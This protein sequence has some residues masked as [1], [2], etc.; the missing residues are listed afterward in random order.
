MTFE[1]LQEARRRLGEEQLEG[2][3][4]QECSE[5]PLGHDWTS[6]ETTVTQQRLL[7]LFRHARLRSLGRRDAYAT[8]R[9]A[10]GFGR[11]AWRRDW[12]LA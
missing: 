10:L 8:W 1:E 7:G 4:E 6:T 5:R 9:Q 11:W 12:R 2:R 3:R